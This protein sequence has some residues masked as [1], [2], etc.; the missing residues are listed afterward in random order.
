MRADHSSCLSE[1]LPKTPRNQERR[2]ELEAAVWTFHFLENANLSKLFMI[3]M[4]YSD[5]TSEGNVSW[6]VVQKEERFV[7]CE[8]RKFSL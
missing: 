8:P 6:T 2:L 3:H 5:K 1:A 7:G 4:F